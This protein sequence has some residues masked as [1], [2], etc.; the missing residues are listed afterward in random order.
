[1]FTGENIYMEH[2]GVSCP[3]TSQIGE[4]HDKRAG[5]AAQA[6]WERRADESATGT[7]K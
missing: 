7:G 6:F 1:M 2:L 4:L 3:V 5:E